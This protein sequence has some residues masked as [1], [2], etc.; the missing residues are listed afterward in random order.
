[1]HVASW[2]ETYDGILS[3][4]FLAGMS[5]DERSTM[6]REII[7]RPMRSF[8]A[9]V[10]GEVV[11]FALAGPAREVESPREIELHAIY[12][13]SDFYGSGLGVALLDAAISDAPAFLWIAAGNARA[14][15]FYRKHGFVLDGATKVE[16]SWENLEERRMTR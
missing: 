1:M 7:D 11:G 14:L 5:T 13:L 16:E 15:S 12:V 4:A 3:D 6:W 8:V 9:E 2:R 10:D